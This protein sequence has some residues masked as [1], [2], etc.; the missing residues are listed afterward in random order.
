MLKTM[1]LQFLDGRQ[2]ISI[3]YGMYSKKLRYYQYIDDSSHNMMMVLVNTDL[4]FYPKDLSSLVRNGFVRIE[5]ITFSE[6]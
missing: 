1:F 2:A 6:L 3:S 5:S 4:A